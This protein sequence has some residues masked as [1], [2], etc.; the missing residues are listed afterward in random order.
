MRDLQQTFEF[1]SPSQ[2]IIGKILGVS[3]ETASNMAWDIRAQQTF[4]AKGFARAAKKPYVL[5]HVEDWWDDAVQAG[6]SIKD[7]I[8]E[9]V[10]AA[11][12]SG[13]V[14]LESVDLDKPE[15]KGLKLLFFAKDQAAFLRIAE[16]VSAPESSESPSSTPALIAAGE[17]E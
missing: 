14:T 17:N 8:W 16:Q 3:M 5:A 6:Q 7:V 1:S 4:L 9:A 12:Y 13:V 11:Y 15:H 2:F 10:R